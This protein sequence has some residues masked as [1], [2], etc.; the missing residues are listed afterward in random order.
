MSAIAEGPKIAALSCGKPVYLVVLLHGEG[1][2][3]AAILDH[4][5]NWAPALP[6]ADFLAAEAPLSG[7]GGAG[8]HW[9][10]GG[11]GVH[12]ALPEAAA[13]L[14]RFLDAALAARRLPDSHLALVGFSQ[15]ATL[16]LCA[17]L[18]RPHPVA[19]VVGFSG[20]LPEGLPAAITAQ[21][22]VLMIHGED[23]PLVPF[24]AMGATKERLKAAGVPA[25]SMRRPGLGHAMDDDGIIAAGDFLTRNLAQKP[26]TAPHDHHH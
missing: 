1:D 18:M 10:D 4:A 17:A 8:R 5:L 15:G 21:P 19:A 11:V 3:G 9:F 14:N 24:A 7:P 2:S 16:A 13:A 26:A 22:Q 12:A 20:A 23:D 25:K 6:K